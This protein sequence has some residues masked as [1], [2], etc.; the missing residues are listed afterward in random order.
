MTSYFRCLFLVILCMNIAA[1]G[2]LIKTLHEQRAYTHPSIP[3]AD[4]SE[5]AIFED[6]FGWLHRI[7]DA[8][9]N[10]ISYSQPSKHALRYVIRLPPGNYHIYYGDNNYPQFVIQKNTRV[11]LEAGHRYKVG[12]KFLSKKGC[13]LKDVTTSERIGGV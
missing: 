13:F 6:D 12:L 5:V 1:C 9:G 10:E 2:P 4:E 11:T 8:D 3:D 7:V